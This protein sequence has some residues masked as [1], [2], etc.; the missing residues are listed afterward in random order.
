MM[1]DSRVRRLAGT[2][3]A[4]EIDVNA[5]ENPVC[6]WWGR[7]WGEIT[8]QSTR[9]RLSS[10][11]RHSNSYAPSWWTQAF[12]PTCGSPVY[13]TNSGMPDLFIVEA[14]SL[15]DPARFA[16]QMVKHLS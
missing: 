10:R 4:E 15:D 8:Q 14:A 13:T 7:H 5:A 9:L 11:H 1:A 6:W 16:P 3:G 12:C 2:Y